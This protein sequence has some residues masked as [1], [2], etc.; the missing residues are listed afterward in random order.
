MLRIIE[1]MRWDFVLAIGDDLTDEDM[2][3]VL[4]DNAYSIKVGYDI[5]AAK[6]RLES[7]AEVRSFLKELCKF[8]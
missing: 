4:P 2:F 7:A 8:K 1:I 3:N 5:S 6:Y